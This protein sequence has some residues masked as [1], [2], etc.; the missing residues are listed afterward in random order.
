[1]KKGRVLVLV[2]LLLGLVGVLTIGQTV[3]NP[4]TFIEAT[5]NTIET[6]DPQFMLSTATTEISNNV[7]DSL[8]DHPHGDLGK[9][10][11][12]IAITVPALENGLI[13]EAPDGTT[14]ISFPIREGVKFHDGSTLKPEDVVYTFKRGLLVGGQAT[15]YNILATTLLGAN[16]F[17][18][19]VDKVG[20]D[21]AYDVLDQAVTTDGH[22][23]TFKLPKPFVP[24][25]GLMSDGGSACGILSKAW[26]V[27]QGAWPGTK[28]TGQNYMNQTMEK[29]PLFDKMMGSGPFKFVSWEPS[30]RVVLDGF[31]EYWAG[32]PEMKQVIR[33]IVPDGQTAI[34]LLKKGDVDFTTVSVS[35]LGQVEGAPGVKVLK[36]L[37]S[38]WLMKINFVQKIADGSSYIGDGK[39]GENG[40]PNDFFSDINVRKAFEY[41]FDWDAF[42][43][44][45]F[46]GA[47]LKPY[48][49]VLIGFPTAN[50]DNPQYYLDLDK[51]KE[52]FQK[53]WNGELWEKGFKFTVAYSSGSTH[54]QRALEILKA[55]IESLNPKFHI[56]LSSLPWA[57]YVGAISNIQLPLSLFGMLPDVFDPYMPLFEHMHSSGGYAEWNGYLEQAKTEFDPLI[58]ELGSNYDPQR[59]KEISYKLQKLDYDNALAI[60]HF[61]AVEHVAMRDWVQGYYTG[62]FP[63]NLDYY[64]LSK[65]Y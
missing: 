55:D 17:S 31:A 64:T 62:P 34:L 39:L 18:D 37:P 56:E 54:R 30:T 27:A 13:T 43:N 60:W 57:A 6:L 7:Y 4:D 65:G 25:L 41:S 45:V 63:F 23:V 53:A 2:G 8:L 51:A 38:T 35:E 1:M 26:C 12:S 48:G 5:T 42:I 24:F 32:A 50:P 19:L 47:A 29:D 44:D 3:N 20:Y 52:Y 10:I 59:R 49:P 9:L 33:K 36:N 15:N 40:I 58:D 28:D 61:Q 46:L 22:S 21:A 16:S 11:P 14:Y